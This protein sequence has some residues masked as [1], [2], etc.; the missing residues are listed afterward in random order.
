MKIAA[1]V[2]TVPLIFLVADTYATPFD[3]ALKPKAIAD[4]VHV[5]EGKLEHFSRDNGGNIVN[6]GFI[7]TSVGAV[8]IDTGPSRRYGE[9]MREAIRKT[10]G[11]DAVQVYITHAHP[12]HFLGDQAFTDIPQSA[13]RATIDAILAGGEDL[14]ANLYRLV[15]GWMEG[16]ESRAPTLEAKAGSVNIGG[17][18]LRLIALQGHTQGDLA[19]FDE[20]TRT[21]FAGDL[22]FLE[23]AP[24]TPNA[25]IDRWLA[26][27]DELH[28]LD[29]AVLVPGHGPVLRNKSALAQTRAYL[30]W[31]SKS[32]GEAARA[33]LDLNEAMRVQPP[34]EFARLAVFREEFERSVVHLYPKLELE[35]LRGTKQHP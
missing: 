9:Q 23:R 10:T 29:I 14:A 24:T 34:A 7:V 16:T 27:L 1:R 17:R 11:K 5:F 35:T 15:G 6:T 28:R 32:L 33:G 18:K 3:Y 2:L 20:A 4:G 25:D 31:L 26:A 30:R 22:A 13:S 19:V 21:L 8:V 12:D